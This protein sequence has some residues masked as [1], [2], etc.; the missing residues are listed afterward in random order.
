[1]QVAPDGS[2]RELAAFGPGTADL[3]FLPGNGTA[4]VPHMQENRVA[5]YDLS[6]VLQ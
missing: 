3:A 2:V 1:M 6:G 5:A 4:I